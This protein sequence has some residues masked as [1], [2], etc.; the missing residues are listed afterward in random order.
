MKL[1]SAERRQPASHQ[2]SAAAWLLLPCRRDW[3]EGGGLL[4][5]CLVNKQGDKSTWGRFGRLMWASHFATLL[6]NPTLN[7]DTT[8]TTVH[9][10]A[11]RPL[12]VREYARVQVSPEPWAVGGRRCIASGCCICVA[13]LV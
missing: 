8:S 11:D 5:E 6:T 13:F 9:P 3:E 1:S 4:P 2:P 7:S 12:T 10:E